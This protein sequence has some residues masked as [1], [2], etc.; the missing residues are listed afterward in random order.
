METD[1]KEVIDYDPQ[2]SPFGYYWGERGADWREQVLAKLKELPDSPAKIADFFLRLGIKGRRKDGCAC[3]VA[4]Y[5]GKLVQ[6]GPHGGRVGALQIH[7]G[8]PGL[9]SVN[10]PTN[11]ELFIM[12][13]DAGEYDCLAEE[14]PFAGLPPEG[15]E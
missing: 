1:R 11:V 8:M 15:D 13:F 10:T 14:T 4:V 7:S 12:Q 9:G 2:G 5:L 6:Y 3:P